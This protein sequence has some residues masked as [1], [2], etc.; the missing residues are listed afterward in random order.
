MLI[1][2]GISIYGSY[3]GVD[4]FGA[5][6]NVRD[7]GPMVA[8]LIG[9]PIVGLGAGLIGGLHRLTMGGFTC[10]PCSLSTILAGVLAGIIYLANKKHFV[11][12]GG[13]VL[14]SVLMESFHMI[15]ALILAS[16]FS[17]AL[18]VVED[19]FIPMILAN[20]MGMFIFALMISNRIKERKTK[21]ERDKL[22]AQ[23]ERRK[24]ELEIA[25]QI[26]ES[27]LPHTIP[28][29]KNYDLAASSIPAQE[30]GGDFYDFIPI[31]SKQTGLTIGDVSGKG[32]P[33]ALFMAF[34]RTLL[35]AKACRN[36]GV[37]RMIE[38]A[39]NFINEEPHSNMF[40]TLFY[41]V[42]DN[43]RNTLTFVNAGHNPPLLLRKKTGDIVRLSTGGVVLGA[44]KGLKMNEKT[45][46]LQTGD[47]LVLYTDGITEA[48]NQQEDQFGEERLIELLKENQELSSGDLKNLIIDQVYDF[49]SGTSQADDITLMVLRRVS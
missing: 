24:K 27:F 31:T 10:I 33:A 44:M 45:I 20:A 22:S 37:G 29:I 12:I 43:A 7:L 8:G 32:I 2:G 21:K 48:I 16:P 9:G 46:D 38:S 15:L 1:F 40:V 6:A 23:L 47:L 17:Q 19:L 5:V 4:I 30:V 25:Q 28:V 26:Q 42:L 11:G 3:S 34:S 18:G 35:R 36:P 14:F 13:A 41:S 49:A 39:N